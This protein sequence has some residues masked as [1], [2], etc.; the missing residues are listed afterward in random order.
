MTAALP[1]LVAL[2]AGCL[3]EDGFQARYDEQLCAWRA[4]CFGDGFESCLDAAADDWS[5][6]GCAFD[7]EA[8]RDCLKDL[9]FM[10]CPGEH[11]DAGLPYAC[12]EVWTC[13]DPG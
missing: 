2:L 1:L 4:D 3:G 7:R 8:A 13:P 6:T 12:A 9:E 5:S 10:D 11:E